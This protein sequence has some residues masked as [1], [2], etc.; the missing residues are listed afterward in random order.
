MSCLYRAHSD[1]FQKVEYSKTHWQ[2]DNNK[3][4]VMNYFLA[5]NEYGLSKNIM[6]NSDHI[7]VIQEWIMNNVE[8]Y[9]WSKNNDDSINF[10]LNRES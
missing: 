6:K 3:R 10:T 4:I 5:G 8:N 1:K 9:Y 7:P 2:E